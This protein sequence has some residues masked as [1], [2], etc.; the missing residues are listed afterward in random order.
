[1]SPHLFEPQQLGGLHLGGHDPPHAAQ[2]PV[3]GAGDASS[4]LLGPVVHPHQ[5]VV[6]PLPWGPGADS[7]EAT[8][9]LFLLVTHYYHLLCC[10]QKIFDM[11][12]LIPIETSKGV[13]I[14]YQI[15]WG[16]R[17]SIHNVTNILRLSLHINE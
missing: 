1:M 5:H 3:A 14:R 12:P 2:G 17:Y 15:P 9:P 6:L 11:V 10:G 16:Y 8:W 13:L 4:L 7:L